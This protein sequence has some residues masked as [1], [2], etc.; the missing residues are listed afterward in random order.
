MP[1]RASRI[2]AI[3]DMFDLTADGYLAIDDVMMI[4]DRLIEARGVSAESDAASAIRSVAEDVFEQLGRADYNDDG[5]VSRDEW[6]RFH[7]QHFDPLGIGDYMPNGPDIAAMRSEFPFYDV[8]GDGK[9]TREDYAF[10]ASLFVPHAAV[11]VLDTHWQVL[12]DTYGREGGIDLDHFI[13]A[14]TVMR[15]S[16]RD[17]PFWFPLDI[18]HSVFPDA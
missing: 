15:C 2:D 17:L 13:Y 5:Q 6:R 9:I 16:L 18:L 10:I 8:N 3:F 1:D 11:E 12:L 4:L 7:E 14:N